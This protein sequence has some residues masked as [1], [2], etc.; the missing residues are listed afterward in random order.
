MT[1]PRLGLRKISLDIGATLARQMFALFLGLGT[2]MIIARALGPDGN[3]QYSLAMLLPTFLVVFFNF[4]ISPANVF[5]VGRDPSASLVAYRAS[6]RIWFVLSAFGVGV[7][8]IVILFKARQWFPGVSSPLIWIASALFPLG[9]LQAYL[10]SLLQAAQDFR[11]YNS[12]MIVSPIIMLV[13]VLGVFLLDG[14]VVGIIFASL[15]TQFFILVFTFFAVRIHVLNKKKVCTQLTWIEYARTAINYG[16][17]SHMSNIITFFNYK[18][19]IFL[20]N[21]FFSPTYAGVYVISVNMAERLWLL[22]Q[23]VSTVIFPRLSELHAEEEV[24]RQLTPLIAR[25]MLIMVTIAACLFAVLGQYL[26]RFIYGLG[27]VGAT[28]PFLF[29]LPG[30]VLASIT[31]ILANDIAARGRPELNMYTSFVVIFINILGN[32][33]LIPRLGLTGAAI[34]TTTAYSVQ[35]VLLVWMYA[36]LSCNCW[37]FLI[38]FGQQDAKIFK[39]IQIFLTSTK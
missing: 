18:I 8:T 7:A 36:R 31:K 1:Q 34:A 26:I 39:Q 6:I 3:G 29:L 37:H 23:A 11:R 10:L 13:L 25:W 12:V 9:L 22:S 17:K 35:A 2:S 14:G 33:Y 19:D 30:M 21:M 20:V 5:Y 32:L 38:S 24:R 15:L 28:E 4:G 27:Y 16:F